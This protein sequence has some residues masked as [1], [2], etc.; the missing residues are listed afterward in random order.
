M[1]SATHSVYNLQLSPISII[2]Y[3][4]YDDKLCE[5]NRSSISY[6]NLRRPW[7][8]STA[9]LWPSTLSTGRHDE[10]NTTNDPRDYTRHRHCHHVK[11]RSDL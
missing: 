4:E 9:E 3:E 2:G 7:Y 5:T 1:Q 6:R 8:H 10:P 11:T